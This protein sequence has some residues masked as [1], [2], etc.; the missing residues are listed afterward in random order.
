MNNDPTNSPNDTPHD[1]NTPEPDTMPVFDVE[2]TTDPTQ[3]K[4]AEST[5][6]TE[7]N[8][9]VADSPF[10]PPIESLSTGPTFPVDPPT[11]IPSV[12]STP[13]ASHAP[14]PVV[15]TDSSATSF[16]ASTFSSSS[17]ETALGASTP[18]PAVNEPSQ[19]PV[20]EPAPVAATPVTAQPKKKKRLG[21]WISLVALVLLLGAAAAG[22]FFVKT[23]A[24]TV[25]D[26]YTA[27]VKTYLDMVY[28]TATVGSSSIT[29]VSSDLAAIDKPKLDDV[30]L[31]SISQKYTQAIDLSKEVAS[32][33]SDFDAT[34]ADLEA[35]FKLDAEQDK[36][37]E[38]VKTITA[39]VSDAKTEA[40]I[41]DVFTQ[42]KDAM[43]ES[44]DSLE[45]AVLPEDL[46][47]AQMKTVAAQDD[48]ITAIEEM[49]SSLTSKNQAAYTAASGDFTKA[50]TAVSTAVKPID[51]YVK[52][53]ATK[54]S[55]AVKELKSFNDTI[56]KD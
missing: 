7:F 27:D 1:Q 54:L 50:S 31:G 16:G 51:E 21:L 17:S 49:V 47:E 34:L 30:F 19:A 40:Q 20:A 45:K 26:A 23:S 38:K 8:P 41:T 56:K 14:E 53:L 46:H 6:T 9:P 42:L 28:D 24:D 35:V 33:T 25:A 4:V 10:G 44:R 11:S 48:A 36:V 3:A 55:D 32:Q 5:P 15:A 18:E 29:T 37:D 2:P 13:V 43:K 12:P 22:Y 52:N 39:S